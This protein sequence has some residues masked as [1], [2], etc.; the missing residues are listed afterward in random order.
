MSDKYLDMDLNDAL[1]EKPYGF[2]VGKNH[3]YLYPASLGVKMLTSRIIDS[4]EIKFSDNPYDD[5]QKVIKSR[6]EEI[7]R[8]IVH[9]TLPNKQ[10]H[11][12]EALITERINELNALNDEDITVLL[13]TVVIDD[14][15]R[16]KKHIGLDKELEEQQKI[17]RLKKSKNTLTFGGKSIYGTIIDTACER[18]GWTMDYVVW[19][20]SY[21][22]L[23]LLL[24]DAIKQIYLTDEEAKKAHV[25][26]NEETMSADNKS[27]MNMIL[28]MNWN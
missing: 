5:I 2:S 6:R 12:N 8:L 19:G 13:Y 20:I 23:S 10:D 17:I 21:T 7:I 11:F 1:L 4:L 14:V 9:Y 15:E 25:N 27:N 22:N 24:S 26:N 28:A 16:F 3:Y 18:Y